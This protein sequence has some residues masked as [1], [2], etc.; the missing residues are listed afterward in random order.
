MT[1]NISNA[2]GTRLVSIP[3][4]STYT[5]TANLTLIGRNAVNFGQQ[6]NQNQINLSQNWANSTAP[7]NP[8]PGQ[9]WYDTANTAYKLYDGITWKAYYPP[10]DGSSGTATAL[11]GSLSTSVVITLDANRII[12]VVSYTRIP[13]S[14]MPDYV[15]INTITYVLSA[16]YPNGL[17]PGFNMA[18]DPNTFLAFNGTATQAT[19]LL[20][21]SN[22]V[23]QGAMTGNAMFD[24]TTD[25]T[26]SV[27]LSNIYVSNTATISGTYTKV[28]LNDAGLVI[29]AGNITAQDVANALG[30][31]PINSNII[32]V[33]SSTNTIA[34]RDANGNF[35]ANI[36]SGT[37]TLTN[38]FADPISLALTGD[39]QGAISFDGTTN[40]IISS[41]L[42]A[43]SG[44][45]A[46]TYSVVNVDT[47]GRILAADIVSGMPL[48]SLV[49]I[50]ADSELP[51]GWI[52]CQ[53]QTVVI[54]DSGVVAAPA[55]S[56]VYVGGSQYAMRVS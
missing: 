46:G 48:G 25:A 45:S 19:A 42:A 31:Q 26:L 43:V 52:W 9:S 38:S 3:D 18:N 29:S 47:T 44:L 30:Y 20:T 8:M 32:N 17:Y 34:S 53:G 21:A 12:H 6:L 50:A 39:L 5:G 28:Q 16:L 1:Y 13:R 7:R 23:V 56:N 10:F 33:Q 40:A 51:D 14:S 27:S 4:S 35:G 22:I 15:T 2:D 54:P 41:N 24:G 55:L 36:M 11:L 37:A 49:L